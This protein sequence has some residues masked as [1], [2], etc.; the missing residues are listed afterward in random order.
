MSRV[1]NIQHGKVNFGNI[2]ALALFSCGA[3]WLLLNLMTDGIEVVKVASV[4]GYG[5]LP[6]VGLA[7]LAVV[8][9]TRCDSLLEPNF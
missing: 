2:Y 6:M 9:P 1:C 3:V 8:I 5:L 4:L 7:Y